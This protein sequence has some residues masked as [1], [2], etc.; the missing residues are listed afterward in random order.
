[1]KNKAIFVW[2]SV[3]NAFF[4]WFQISE[5]ILAKEH[6]YKWTVPTILLT[7]AL[8]VIVG[9]LLSY[10]F[11]FVYSTVVKRIKPRTGEKEH[12]LERF[13]KFP[14][15]W[16]AFFLSYVPMYLIFY[17][18]ICAYDTNV[19]LEQ[20]ISGN[21]ID[22]HPFLHTMIIKCFYSLGE[23]LGNITLGMGLFVL[24]QMLAL[25][26]GLAVSVALLK[27]KGLG[28]AW[29][30]AIVLFLL[31]YPY[32]VFMALSVTKAA[33]F[34]AAFVPLS[35]LLCIVLAEKKKTFRPSGAEIAVF[36]L[37]FPVIAFR[38]NARYALLVLCVMLLLMTV[39]SK[40]NRRHYARALCAI[41]FGL[42]TSLLIIGSLYRHFNVTQA[43]RREM[44]SVPIQQLAR[45]AYYHSDELSEEEMTEINNFILDE[46]WKDYDPFLADPAKKHVN[47][48][49]LL[50][51]PKGMLN[52][53][54]GLLFRYPGDYVNAVLSLDAGY[55]YLAD[56]SCLRIYGDHFGYGL[57]QTAGADIIREYGI[58][59]KGMFKNALNRVEKCLSDN[60]IQNIPVL[61]IFLRPASVL[62]VYL[63][64]GLWAIHRKR[65]F[66]FAS[67]ILALAYIATLLVGPT[68]Q[69]RYIYPV[70]ALL[71]VLIATGNIGKGNDSLIT[72]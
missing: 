7:V 52:T 51:N 1:M 48:N 21:Y 10:I 61:G 29:Q 44:L 55:L 46:A 12:R 37:C 65:Y 47:T 35:V 54:T 2:T 6:A 3:L 14:V 58:E 16:A 66:V 22:H 27:K 24:L 38:T 26:A 5:F 72:L 13:V 50:V 19:Q 33:L 31:L 30:V 36:L 56:K 18:G 41:G 67:E 43:D 63:Y 45:V 23:A 34:T 32:H 28:Y 39:F 57:V 4:V 53:Y 64:F 17:P 20:V 49:R 11:F 25:S 62:W 68:V 70:M 40:T 71:P 42:V 9:I 69:L 60:T 15:L 8:S 59:R